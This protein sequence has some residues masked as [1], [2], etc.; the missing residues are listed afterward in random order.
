MCSRSP[1]H[2]FYKVQLIRIALRSR[3]EVLLQ[4]PAPSPSKACDPGHECGHAEH[5]PSE[6][7]APRGG[8][9]LVLKY[10]DD[11]KRT[12]S[13]F[14]L[15]LD[16]PGVATREPSKGSPPDIGEAIAR[17]AKPSCPLY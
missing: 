10:L 7:S 17:T 8:T 12:T 3:T 2:K 16:A 14:A 1:M 9:A 13:S 4:P 5:Q 6:W 15:P 11:V